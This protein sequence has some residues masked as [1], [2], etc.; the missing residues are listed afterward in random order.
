TSPV[1]LSS[2]L[3]P[4]TT[5][6]KTQYFDNQTWALVTLN[7]KGG[8]GLAYFVDHYDGSS[9]I[10]VLVSSPNDDFDEADVST[11]PNDL[12]NYINTNYY[13]EGK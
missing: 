6:V 3:S 8:I 2:Q 12:Q 7:V 4:S 10:W 13:V 9:G 11:M 1:S 5:V